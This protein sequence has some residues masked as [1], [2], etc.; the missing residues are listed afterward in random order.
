MLDGRFLHLLLACFVHGGARPLNEPP[1]PLLHHLPERPWIQHFLP[2][3][4]SSSL[5]SSPK[6][7]WTSAA[8][9]GVKLCINSVNALRHWFNISVLAL[10]VL[11]L[12]WTLIVLV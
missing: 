1:P 5:P 10:E 11:K 4:R 6:I 9:V 2:P 12:S 3:A 7:Q 8:V